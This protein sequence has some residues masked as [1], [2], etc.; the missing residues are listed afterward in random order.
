MIAEY[1]EMLTSY[2]GLDILTIAVIG[3]AV[4]LIV[5]ISRR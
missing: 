1:L 3:C 5:L 2:T 4:L